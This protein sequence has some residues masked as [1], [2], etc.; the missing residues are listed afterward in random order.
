[1]A[2]LE[3]EWQLLPPHLNSEMRFK[4][5]LLVTHRQIYNRHF[6]LEPGVNPA[7]GFHLLGYRRT[8]NWRIVFALTPWMLSRLL[9]AETPPVIEIPD[10]WRSEQRLETDYQL[11]GPLVDLPLETG[12][13]QAHLNFHSI[14]GHYLVQPLTLNMQQYANAREV[15]KAW[16]H[17]I[18]IQTEHMNKL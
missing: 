6:A 1:M 13:T 10:G 11:L 16:N 3:L 8:E 2:E 5:A 14:L 7:L 4:M 18:E 9:F 17:V 12:G 15:L